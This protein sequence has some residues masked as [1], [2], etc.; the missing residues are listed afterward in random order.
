MAQILEK[1]VENG[2]LSR[3][4]IV[5][6]MNDVGT[7]KTGGLLSD[8]EYGGPSDRVFPRAGRIF[9]IDPEKGLKAATELFT[10]DG[11]KEFELEE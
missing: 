5:A 4:G 8:Y 2:D 9:S 3:K 6:A 7:L 1:A 11:A 10:S